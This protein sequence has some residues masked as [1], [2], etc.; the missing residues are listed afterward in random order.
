MCPILHTIPNM[1]YIKREILK[2]LAPYIK[3]WGGPVTVFRG[4]KVYY[5]SSSKGSTF[6]SASRAAA[7]VYSVGGYG[8]FTKATFYVGTHVYFEDRLS[9]E[10]VSFVD[11]LADLAKDSGCELEQKQSYRMGSLTVQV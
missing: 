1:Q 5:A 7:N 10:F 4:E 9:K 8:Q 3:R 6:W 2:H 11:K